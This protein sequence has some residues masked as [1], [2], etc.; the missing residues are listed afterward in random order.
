MTSEDI[1]CDFLCF[2]G[3]KMLGPTGTGVL[4]IKK[5][6]QKVEPL[7]S[8][9]GM[10]EDVYDGSYDI[11]K[12]YEGFEAGTP[13]I[14]AGIGLGAAVDYLNRVGVEEIHNHEKRLTRKLLEGLAGD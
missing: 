14:S 7:L 11:K 6:E 10:V 1:D 9:G 8:G 12:G 2:S 5:A 3:H 4:W 13:D